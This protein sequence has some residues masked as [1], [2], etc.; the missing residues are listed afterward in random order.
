MV[1]FNEF[2]E[3]DDLFEIALEEIQKERAYLPVP[4]NVKLLRDCLV[5]MAHLAKKNDPESKIN[6]GVTAIGRTSASITVETTDF[7]TFDVEH[8]AQAIAKAHDIE[9]YP[10]VDDKVRITVEF[11]NV[12][13]EVPDEEE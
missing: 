3:Y 4:E 2:G 7:T 9:I 11:S 10:L 6:W 5:V 1:E 12:F 8:F 13:V